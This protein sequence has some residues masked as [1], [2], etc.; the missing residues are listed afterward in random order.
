M[1]RSDEGSYEVLVVGATGNIGR[2]LVELLAA[3]GERVRAS[4]RHPETYAKRAGV[5]P[6]G[7]DYDRPATWPPA[8]DGIDRALILPAVV[9]CPEA[10]TI[11]IIDEARNAGVR[12]VVLVTA[13]GVEQQEM[14][15]HSAAARSQRAIELHLVESGIA[16]TI[17]RPNWFM[18]N[19][20]PGFF[21]TMIR[22]RGG[23]YLP[24]A[25]SRTSH[26]DTRDIAAVAAAA[27]TEAGHEGMEYTLTGP[28]ALDFDEVAHILS[29]AT[30]R[31]ISY[32]A[33]SD[34]EMRR[35]LATESWPRDQ[36]EMTV[37]WLALM[38]QGWYAPVSASVTEILRRPPIT[39]RQFAE[40]NAEA[41]R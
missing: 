20:N 31:E 11:P 34:T 13:M 27:L 9:A 38:R 8:F 2:P 36:I 18:Q 39:L 40:E 15:D 24:T 10:T 3:Q 30:G 23:L 41:W 33:I 4:T 28:E 32:V 7:F 6:V 21:L 12:R 26:I 37:S 16:Y 19:L 17:L 22:E 35:D 25:D 5:E 29:E 1:G 14:Q